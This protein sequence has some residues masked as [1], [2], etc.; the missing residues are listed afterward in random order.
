MAFPGKTT[1]A[2]SSGCNDLIKQ[3]KAAL[4]ENADDLISLMGWTPQAHPIQQALFIDL[5][6][7]EQLAME[8][9]R[10][11][12]AITVDELA[13]SMKQTVQ[14]INT[15]LLNLEFSGLVKALPGNRFK[16]VQKNYQATPPI[17]PF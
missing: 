14:Q 3:N 15:L 8:L 12:N 10:S 6:T 13:R 11:N 2:Y 7:E 17:S 5:T 16:I 4:I 1:D 9:L